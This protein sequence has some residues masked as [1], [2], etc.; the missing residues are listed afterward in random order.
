MNRRAW[1]GV[2][3]A[4]IPASQ[5]GA[6]TVDV[7]CDAGSALGPA[8]RSLKPG[9]TVLVGGTCRENLVIQAEL[10]GITIEGKGKAAIDAPDASLPAIQVLGREVTI[11]GLTITGGF[12][13]IAINR[14][15]TAVIDRIT[16]EN[17][18]HSDIEV[19][20]NSF[21]RIVNT[22]I[23]RCKQNGIMVM[24]S[25]SAHIGVLRSDDKAPSPNI[26][27]SNGADGISVLR[28][29]TARIIGNSLSGNRR[30]GLAIQQVSHADV[31]GNVFDENGEAGIRV[32]GNSGVNLADSVMRLFEQPNKTNRPNGL[33]ASVAK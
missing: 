30:N 19:S 18:S 26:I 20:Q 21:G 33:L 23:Q 11:R 27:K 3:L 2:V 9:D 25:S 8:F 31:A 1:L 29:S 24:G 6:A 17:A 32:A 15:A 28:A 12:F 14:G 10:Q 13:G 4:L 5:M 7:D 22:T 16:I